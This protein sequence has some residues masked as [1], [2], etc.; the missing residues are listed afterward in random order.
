[1]NRSIHRLVRARSLTAVLS[2]AAALALPTT[3][4][5][6]LSA[7][8]LLP[9]AAHAA[10]RVVGSGRTATEARKVGDFEAISLNGSIDITV[11]QGAETTVRATADDNLLPLLETIVESGASG[12]RLVVRWKSGTNLSTRNKVQVQVV[13]PRLVAL[14]SAGSGDARIESFSTPSL[15]LSLAGSGDAALPG[16]KAED[17]QISIAGS[18]DVKADGQTARLK[19]TVAGSG[20]VMARELRADDVSVSIAGSGDVA[21]QA[22]KKLAVSIAGSGDVVYTGEAEVTRTVVGSGSVKRR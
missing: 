19:I 13:T 12:P 11:R 16:L 6:M 18:G 9:A 14:G 15:K 21:V 10:E 17:L 20:D 5:L 7:A 4:G 3:I 22:Q 1:M 8:L 2:A